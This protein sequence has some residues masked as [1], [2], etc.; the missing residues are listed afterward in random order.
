MNI[1]SA[2]IAPLCESLSESYPTP[3]RPLRSGPDFVP[4]AT[5]IPA[6]TTMSEHTPDPTPIFPQQGPPR[7]WLLHL[8]LPP[9]GWVGLSQPWL[10]CPLL[11]EAFLDDPF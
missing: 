4:S 5:S 10:R 9:P 6:S 2:Y 11:G 1:N 3:A 7:C 8:L